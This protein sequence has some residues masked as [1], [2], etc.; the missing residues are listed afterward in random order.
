MWLTEWQ[1]S[2]CD[3]AQVEL[4]GICPPECARNPL[5]RVPG[6]AVH[7]EMTSWMQSPAKT[8][9]GVAGRNCRPLGA[10][11]HCAQRGSG[12]WGSCLPCRSGVAGKLVL[13]QVSAG[14]ATCVTGA[15]VAETAVGTRGPSPGGA[16]AV[17]TACC[18]GSIWGGRHSPLV[19]SLHCPLLTKPSITPVEKENIKSSAH[20]HYS[21]NKG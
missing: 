14:G 1:G 20:F 16:S 5:L 6:K 15:P 3:A 12:S 21:G 8:P 4:A 10:A 13:Q 2:H 11:D 9:E 18:T 19:M 17:A 7:R